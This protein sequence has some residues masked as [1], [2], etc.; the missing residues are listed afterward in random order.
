MELSATGRAILGMLSIEPK[1]GYDIKTLADKSARFFWAASYGQIYPELKRL[2]AAG[3]AEASEPKGER[4]RTVYRITPSG[5]KA[6]RDWIVATEMT[7]ELRDEG[8][9]KLFFAGALGRDEAEAV[10]RAKRAAH[11]AALD[12]LRDIEPFA[13]QAERFGP[14]A[15]LRYGL[16]FNEFAIRWCDHI[17]NELEN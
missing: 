6:V 11:Q 3:L 8:L 7:H 14:H 9:L 16:E 4:K 5:K 2:A 17:L 13:A 15:V 10:V 1:S 12:E